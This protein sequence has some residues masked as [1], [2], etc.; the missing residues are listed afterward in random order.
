MGQEFAHSGSLIL[1]CRQF[2]TIKSACLCIRS[3]LKEIESLIAPKKG[4]SE[5]D[6]LDSLVT[7]VE[8]YER[9]VFTLEMPDPV[10]A[11]HF[12]MEQLG[13][14]PKDLQPMI[15]QINRVYEF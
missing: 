2:F 1:N 12:R 5:G 9:K 15:C 8:A 11:I 14:V 4:S 7:L 13:L 10:A 3:T 6:R